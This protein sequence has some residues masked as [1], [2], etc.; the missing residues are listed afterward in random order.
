LA[1]EIGQ[2]DAEDAKVSQRTQKQN[3]ILDVF[4]CDLCETSA[5]SASGSPYSLV[6]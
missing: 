3:Q 4:F 5:S 1:E 2:P 6:L